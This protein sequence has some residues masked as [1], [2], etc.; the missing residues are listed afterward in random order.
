MIQHFERIPYLQTTQLVNSCFR[1]IMF[2]AIMSSPL[3]LAV[4]G[5][6]VPE[7][8]LNILWWS[9]VLSMFIFMFI[10]YHFSIPKKVSLIVDDDLFT[11]SMESGCCD[12]RIKLSDI[13]DVSIV[14]WESRAFAYQIKN[15]DVH[16]SMSDATYRMSI[17]TQRN[18]VDV[19][20]PNIEHF[21]MVVHKLTK[22]GVALV[23]YK[24][25]L[26]EMAAT[27]NLI[28][29]KE[30]FNLFEPSHKTIVSNNS[31]QK[32]EY[33][34]INASVA[35]NVSLQTEP[36]VVYDQTQTFSP[37][38]SSSQMPYYSPQIY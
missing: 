17:R 21:Y 26:S 18:M 33:F 12:Q 19:A 32:D 29:S 7:F 15:G 24:M 34:D 20:V 10:I 4:V 5:I 1:K 36:F 37:Y 30:C 16:L 9:F 11:I 35:D 27:S 6:C 14:S 25:P 28:V 38:E 3:V 8:R 13:I 23:N 2:W 22:K 31:L